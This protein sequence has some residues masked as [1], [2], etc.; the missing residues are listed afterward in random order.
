MIWYGEVPSKGGMPNGKD[1]VL[2]SVVPWAIKT[3][4]ASDT[5]HAYVEFIV[6][7]CLPPLP[8]NCMKDLKS[9]AIHVIH[10][11]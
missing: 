4:G 2:D 10:I 5:S 8:L 1:A 3:V 9:L 6:R 7:N 11:T